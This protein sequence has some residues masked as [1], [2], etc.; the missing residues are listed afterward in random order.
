MAY[1]WLKTLHVVAVVCWMAGLFY[2]GRVV[3]NHVEALARPE[4][5]RT[6]LHEQLAG[7]SRRAYRG[8]LTPAAVLTLA[9]AAG[10]LAERP[11][12]LGAGWLQA[13]LALVALLGGF[14]LYCGR[15]VAALAAGRAPVTSLQARL[16]NEVPTLFL[17]AIAL[18]A[19][20]K[21]A[22]TPRTVAQGVGGL[23]VLLAVGVA[24]YA[25]RRARAGRPV[26][27]AGVPAR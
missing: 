15:L 11:A 5:A 18:L 20:F 25:R 10:M 17:L 22:A 1:L 24:Q 7:M 26:P 14:H 2:V 8:I 3:V 4:P 19:V 13:K 6:I 27:L 9:F 16:L 23:L 12:L 21:G